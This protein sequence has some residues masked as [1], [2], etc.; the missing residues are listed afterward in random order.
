MALNKYTRLLAELVAI[1]SA[2][3]MELAHDQSNEAVIH[4][5]ANWCE[6]LSMRTEVLTIEQAHHG[7][8]TTKKNLIATLGEG[9][10]GLVLSGHTDTVPVNHRL[11]TTDPYKLTEKEDKLFGI[12]ATDMKGFFPVALKAIESLNIQPSKL[13]A[14][15]IILATADEESGMAGAKALVEAQQ[16]KATYACLLYTSPSPRDS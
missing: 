11:W 9:A 12:G 16:P 4:L 2:S 5:L 7:K 14:P 3:S 13:K 15:I 8:E 10:G 6:S 1:P